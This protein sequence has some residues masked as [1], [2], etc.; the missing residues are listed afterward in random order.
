[1]R[2]PITDGAGKP[3][4]FR[5]KDLRSWWSNHHTDRPGGVETGAP[6][7]WVPGS[8]PI[9]FTEIGCP[10]IDLGANQP[11]V[12]TDPKSSESFAPSFSRGWRDDAMQRAYLEAA[13]GDWSDPAN[14][15]LSSVY[16]GQMVHVPTCAAWA[17]DPRSYPFFLALTDVWTDGANWRLGH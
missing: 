15:P 5:T 4:V 16:G 11:K 10:A 9:R 14:N 13:L 7:A 1:V 6:T 8:K 2:T 12:F 3:W 17:W